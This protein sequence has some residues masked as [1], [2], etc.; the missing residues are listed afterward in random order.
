MY[1]T[2]SNLS[3]ACQ[4]ANYKSQL[5]QSLSN[6]KALCSQSSKRQAAHYKSTTDYVIFDNAAYRKI[7]N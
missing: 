5:G 6:E 3:E 2:S 1:F 4:Q 7:M